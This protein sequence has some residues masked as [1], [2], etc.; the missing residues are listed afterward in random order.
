[1]NAKSL[2]VRALKQHH[3]GWE[4]ADAIERGDIVLVRRQDLE[5]IAELCADE[6]TQSAL[7]NVEAIL[8]RNA[9]WEP[10]A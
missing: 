3:T 9:A 6:L 10:S 4:F 7:A 1:V 5:L 8:E 2:I